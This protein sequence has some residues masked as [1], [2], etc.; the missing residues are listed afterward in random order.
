MRVL[1]V[2]ILLILASLISC[3][4]SSKNTS[5]SSKTNRVAANSIKKERE[6]LNNQNATP[7]I[8]TNRPLL[9]S[10]YTSLEDFKSTI[11]VEYFNKKRDSDSINKGSSRVELT[12]R[13]NGREVISILESGIDQGDIIKVRDG[14]LWNHIG[15]I[16]SSPYAVSQRR[17]LSKIYLLAR[18]KSDIFGEGAV[19]FFDLAESSVKNITTIDLAYQI[20]K[21]SSE[22]GYV[23]TFN[24]IT[25]QA[26]I[27][28]LF[29]EEIADFIADVHERYSMPELTTGEFTHEQL[30]DPNNYPVDNYVDI[31]N[32]EIGQDIGNQLKAK[33]LINQETYWTSELLTNYLND[34]QGYYCWAF[35]IGMRP[36]RPQ[37]EV[38]VQFSNKINSVMKTATYKV[39]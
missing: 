1:H 7:H 29:S 6:D 23:N 33:Y 20:P 24:H 39:K 28:S 32:N 26:L 4:G 2:F 30:N 25:A 3:N 13:I 10:R 36:F 27:T 12:Y 16:F 9:A 11:Q 37:D 5:E 31:I 38:I 35:K 21:D 15:L 17:P 14:N 34:I 8:L 18:R 19:A 22:K